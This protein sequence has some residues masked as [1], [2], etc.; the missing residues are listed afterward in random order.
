MKSFV[1]IA[2]VAFVSVLL[3]G[4][5]SGLAQQEAYVPLEGD[6]VVIYINKWKAEGFEMAKQI[7]KEFGDHMTASGQSRQTYWAA[8]PHSY[9][10]VSISFFKKGDSVDAWH[11]NEGRLKVLKNLALLRRASPIVHRYRVIGVHNTK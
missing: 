1:Q 10:T 7:L 6:E 5:L 4:A 3:M 2:T 8:D 9:E 11:T